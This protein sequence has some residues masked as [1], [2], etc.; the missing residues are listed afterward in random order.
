MTVRPPT[1][2]TFALTAIVLPT[3]DPDVGE[4]IVTINLLRSCAKAGGAE[5]EA[6]PSVMN[7][8][9]APR[10]VTRDTGVLLI[11]FYLFLAG[12]TA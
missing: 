6:R 2:V 7:S 8:A 11:V 12:S 5:S 9:A 4:V 1:I 3:V 10:G